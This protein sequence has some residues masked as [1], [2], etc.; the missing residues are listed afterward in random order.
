[1]ERKFI[2]QNL[3]EIFLLKFIP[4]DRVTYSPNTELRHISQ[5]ISDVLY[6]LNYY[7]TIETVFTAFENLSYPISVIEP[8][9]KGNISQPYVQTNS[10]TIY[11]GV[12][13]GA[14]ERVLEICNYYETPGIE[15]SPDLRKSY[16]DFLKL[17]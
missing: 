8:V 13:I 14:L 6:H 15:L 7:M 4:E 9:K 2:N 1:M 5:V 17:I 12:Q 3:L 10:N 16:L 11:I